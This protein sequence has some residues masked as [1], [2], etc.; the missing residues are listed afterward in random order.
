[1]QWAEDQSPEHQHV[2][3][4]FEQVHMKM[5]YMTDILTDR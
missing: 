3:G 5:S 2:Q 1:V 4:A